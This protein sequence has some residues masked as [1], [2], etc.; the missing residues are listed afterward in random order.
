MVSLQVNS[1]QIAQAL[2]IH[3]GCESSFRHEARYANTEFVAL[4]HLA[5]G[6]PQ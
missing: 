6:D 3:L 5:Y 2:P 4:A 1:L